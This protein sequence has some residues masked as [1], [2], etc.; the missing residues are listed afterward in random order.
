MSSLFPHHWNLFYEINTVNF[1]N[2]VQIKHILTIP[3]VMSLMTKCIYKVRIHQKQKQESK[4]ILGYTLGVWPARL[5]IYER[6]S[7]L[8]F[9]LY[10]NK[11]ICLGV[12]GQGSCS[13]TPCRNNATCTDGVAGPVCT[14]ITG[15][16]GNKCEVNVDDCENS[17]CYF[18]GTCVDGINGYSCKCKDGFVGKNH[19]KKLYN[20]TINLFTFLVCVPINSDNVNSD[21]FTCKCY[22]I[23]CTGINFGE[24]PFYFSTLI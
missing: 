17:P 6:E 1:I 2:A 12:Q 15:F 21:H 11:I 20:T 7:S 3:K 18:N 10:I 19:T 24:K 23:I 4:C 5:N 14:C 13:T 22:T 8:I 16:T 9:G